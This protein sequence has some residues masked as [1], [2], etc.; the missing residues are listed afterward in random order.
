MLKCTTR[1][2]SWMAP[3]LTRPETATLTSTS[4]YVRKWVVFADRPR[5]LCVLYSLRLML[6]NCCQLASLLRL[7]LSYYSFTLHFTPLLYCSLHCS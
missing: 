1:V 4:R 2:P 6:F 5:I 3:S 7:M